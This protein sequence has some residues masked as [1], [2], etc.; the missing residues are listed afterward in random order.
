MLIGFTRPAAARFSFIMSIPAL[1]GAGVIAL[2]D[3]VEQGNLGAEALSITVGF[4]VAAISGYAC[5]RWLLRY[6]QS[7]SLYIF[8]AYCFAVSLLTILVAFIRG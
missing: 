4:V 2:A 5:I 6:L 7:H 8:A 3:L 1:L